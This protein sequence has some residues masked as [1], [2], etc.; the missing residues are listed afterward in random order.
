MNTKYPPLDIVSP[1]PQLW[2]LSPTRL[3]SFSLADSGNFLPI[4]AMDNF[5]FTSGFEWDS[6]PISW[7]VLTSTLFDL[8]NL[9]MVIDAQPIELAISVADSPD[10]Y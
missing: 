3:L 2:F 10:L 8:S 1:P 4:A 9:M 5:I 6:F 7:R